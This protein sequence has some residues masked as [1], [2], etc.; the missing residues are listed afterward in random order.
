MGL[1]GA[2]RRALS[3]AAGMFA[4]EGLSLRGE[5]VT[6]AWLARVREEVA[7][8]PAF[9]RARMEDVRRVALRECAQR[10]GAGAGF[11]DR[12][13]TEYMRA[14]HAEVRLYPDTLG[15]LLRLREM[16]CRL[17]L[18]TNGNSRPE[19]LGLGELLEHTVVAAD[20]GH[21]KPDPRIYRYAAERF[22][23]APAECLHVGDHLVEDVDASTEAGMA[24][25]WIN[26]GPPREAEPGR[27]W[28]TVTTLAAV[29]ALLDEKP[30]GTA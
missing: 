1:S 23:V 17:G 13:F 22:G 12:V 18:V 25:V 9:A 30:A 8:R 21:R 7:A 16:G 4:A 29:P 19:P 26:R 15:C 28:R 10:A 2:M 20:C 11:A 24:A 27:A 6:G 14:R 3:L 5:P